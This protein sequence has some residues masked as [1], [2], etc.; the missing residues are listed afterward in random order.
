MING[1][2]PEGVG[3]WLLILCALLLIWQPLSLGLL[4]SSVLDSLAVRGLPLAL[5]L[6]A[7]VNTRPGSCHAD[8]RAT[9]RAAERFGPARG[10]PRG[11]VFHRSRFDARAADGH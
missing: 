5:V 3:G 10:S 6:A 1:K 9:A 7:R 8:C 2:E 4:A 11:S